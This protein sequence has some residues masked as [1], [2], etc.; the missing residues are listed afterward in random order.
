MVKVTTQTITYTD[1]SRTDRP[2]KTTLWSPAEIDLTK[3]VKKLPLILLSH[4]SGS[5]RLSLAWLARP[6][7]EQG[8]IVAAP[9]HF[10]NTFDHPEPEQF[11]RYWE[12]P[13]DLSFLLSQLQRDYGG[14]IDNDQIFAIG[15]SLG[16]YSVLALAGVNVDQNLIKQKEKAVLNV[17]QSTD[18]PTFGKLT[19]KVVEADPSEVPP[20]L[21]DE[22]FRKVVALSPALGSGLGSFDQTKNVEIPILLIAPGGDKIAPVDLNGRVYHHFLPAAKYT[23]LPQNVGHFIFLPYKKSFPS[24][25]AFWYQD[26]PGVDRQQIHQQTIQQISQFLLK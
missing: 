15:F 10:G 18:M 4:G 8:C 14:V 19:G 23:E 22:R 21:K 16:A 25:D 24:A 17:A 3:A 26:A 11:K 20:D 13:R 9:D 6:L 2:L 5:N 12:R 7:A 1:P